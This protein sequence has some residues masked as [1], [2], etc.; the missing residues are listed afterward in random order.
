MRCGRVD[1]EN[2]SKSIADKLHEDVDYRHLVLTIPAQF[3]NIFYKNR[4]NSDL[5]NAFYSAGWKFVNKLMEKVFGREV[6]CG[7]V[8]VLHT[9]GRKCDYKPHL[10]ILLMSGGINSEGEWMV[11]KNFYY[12]I[13]QKLWKEVLLSAIQDWDKKGL[14]T[15]LCK[16]S[17]SRVYW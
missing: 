11:L 13:I 12:G 6:E 3:R 9:V 16:R 5:F 14:L 7:S 15:N 17:R 10:H 1:G 2:F 4:H 8:M